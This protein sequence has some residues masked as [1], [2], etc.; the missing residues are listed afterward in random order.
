ME[1]VELSKCSEF[2]N[3]GSLVPWETRLTSGGT[4]WGVEP[5]GQ[6]SGKIVFGGEK[7]GGFR[8]ERAAGCGAA[9]RWAVDAGVNQNHGEPLSLDGDGLNRR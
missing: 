1:F 4:L 8:G 7:G 3:G 2:H 5:M 6:R 9:S